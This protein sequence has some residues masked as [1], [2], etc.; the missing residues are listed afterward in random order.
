MNKQ[1]ALRERKH[2]PH[3]DWNS[4]VWHETVWPI[5]HFVIVLKI[6]W[7]SIPSLFRNISNKRRSRKWK[8]KSCIQVVKRN[9]PKTFPIV[10]RTM[11]DASWNF[12]ENPFIHFTGMLLTDTSARPDGRVWNSLVM[13]ETV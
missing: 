13:R 4:L 8:N 7:I 3:L 10:P 11:A 1:E 12:H 5:A 9:I 6:S 2:P